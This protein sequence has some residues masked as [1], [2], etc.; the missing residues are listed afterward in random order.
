MLRQSLAGL[1]LWLALGCSPESIPADSGLRVISLSP[2]ITA[3]VVAL[4][5][6]DQLVGIDR[7][8]R[9]VKGVGHLPSLGGLFAPD[10][11][12]AVELRPTLVL[13][14]SSAQQTG[15]FAQLRAR[16]VRVREL[17]PYTLG[18]VFESY[19]EIGDLLDRDAEPL[20]AR[21]R[22]ELEQ[23][24][25]S[26]LNRP[27]PSV[28]LV[29]ERD[30]VYVAAGGTFVDE[31][32]RVAGGRNVFGDLQSRYPQVSLELLA[33]RAPDLL[34]DS[35]VPD[36][37]PARMAEARAHW[38]RFNWIGRVE[39]IAPGVA[40]VPGTDLAEGARLL[41]EQIHPDLHLSQVP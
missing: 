39:F 1:M 29:I 37:D 16:G 15:F 32:I 25:A 35:T 8:S 36:L 18:E 2:S 19:R 40:T 28:A 20:I 33:E 34:I 41:R 21:I 14:V 4:G 22:A 38:A 5:A 23:I 9:D 27:R 30:P 12:R 10:L 17:E 26:S 13:A 31:L 6:T 3:I 11:E 24:R 7:Y